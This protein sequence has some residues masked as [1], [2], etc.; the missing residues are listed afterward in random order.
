MIFIILFLS[1][2]FLMSVLFIRAE[3]VYS[4]DMKMLHIVREEIGHNDFYK[5]MAVFDEK[6]Y[7]KRVLDIRYWT[8]NQV[9]PKAYNHLRFK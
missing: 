6:S 7:T 2:L 5:V 9:F 1:S 3:L 4:Y 8:F